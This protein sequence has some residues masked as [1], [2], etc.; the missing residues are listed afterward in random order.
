MHQDVYDFY[1]FYVVMVMNIIYNIKELV[2]TPLLY[3][4]YYIGGE[5]EQSQ[6]FNRRTMCYF[7][8]FS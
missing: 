4:A 5:E 3:R 2:H 6:G 7:T 1:I 8:K